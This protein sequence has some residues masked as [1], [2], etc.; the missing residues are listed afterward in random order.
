MT[1]AV[2]LTLFVLFYLPQM[3]SFGTNPFSWNK[4]DPISGAVGGLSLTRENGSVIPVVNLSEEI[5]VR[6]HII[7]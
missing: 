7:F 2:L 4:S 6:S 3:L 5:E 1:V